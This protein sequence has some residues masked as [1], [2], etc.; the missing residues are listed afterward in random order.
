MRTRTGVLAGAFLLAATAAQPVSAQAVDADSRWQ[1]FLGCWAPVAQED[2]QPAPD[3]VVC[4]RPA[5]GGA[6]VV[7]V[8]GE[9]ISGEQRLLPDAGERAVKAEQCEG[10]ESAAWSQDGGRIYVHSNL[11]CGENVLGRKSA[12]AF[13]LTGPNTLVEVEAVGVDNEYGV[14]VQQYRLLAASEYPESLRQLATLGN[15]AARLSAAAPLSMDDIVEASALLPKQALQ[16]M[17]VTTPTAELDV[18]RNTLVALSDAG[19]DPDVIDVIIALAYP[20]RFAVAAAPADHDDRRYAVREQMYLPYYDAF[21]Y[22][23]YGRYG[24]YGYNP[25]YG[26]PFG[27]GYG[28]YTG[29]TRVI[30]VDRDSESDAPARGRLVKGRGFTG[31]PSSSRGSDAGTRSRPAIERNPRPSTSTDA[32]ATRSTTTTTSTPSSSS[33]GRRAVPRPPS[34]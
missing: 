9:R 2:G 8:T 10:T 22:D 4:F 32:S 16:A 12:G 21:R 17:L 19:V 31:P 24:Y 28:W 7:T 26:S 14:R 25:Y 29:G 6:D 15:A 3:H 1:A 5:D 18:D 27:Y 20:E 34:N 30:I 33:T 23:P 13:T 11:D